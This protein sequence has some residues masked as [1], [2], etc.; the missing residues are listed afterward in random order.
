VDFLHRKPA[1]A[2][3]RA[4]CATGAAQTSDSVA[5]FRNGSFAVA[6]M[7]ACT[8]LVSFLRRAQVFVEAANRQATPLARVIDVVCRGR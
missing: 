6:L 3:T 8:A 5:A 4:G 1:R 7:M 2:G